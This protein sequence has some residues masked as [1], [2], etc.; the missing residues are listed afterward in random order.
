MRPTT[1]KELK[2]I[3]KTF[4]PFLKEEKTQKYSTLFL[5]LTALSLF[6]IFAINPTISTIVHLQKQLSDSKFVEKSLQEKIETLSKL[7]TEFVSLKEVI[8]VILKAIPEKPTVPL[9]AAQLQGVAQANNIEVTRLQIFQVELSKNTTNQKNY[10]SFGF[11]L[12][13]RGAQENLTSFLSSLIDF[14]RIIS[15]DSISFG[16]IKEKDSLQIS[17]QGK[18][19]FKP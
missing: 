13:I 15:I 12:D 4:A 14:E 7:Q 8:P 10:G 9:F 17:L 16:S 19:Y 6:G 3:Y 18:A 1:N 2:D 11:T 5:T